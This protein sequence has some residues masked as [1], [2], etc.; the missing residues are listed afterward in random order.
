VVQYELQPGNEGSLR[1]PPAD[2]AASLNTHDMPPFRAFWEGD[3]VGDLEGRGLFDAGEAA[4]ERERR[5]VLRRGMAALLPRAPDP[6]DPEA[7]G[8]AEAVLADRLE[9]LAAG[10]ARLVLVNLEDLWG[11][12]APQNVP[13]TQA[14]R[15]NWRRKA[16]LSFEELSARPE[17]VE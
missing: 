12:T 3:D 11:E 15:P 6:P 7:Q 13:G 1:P 9:W 10:P 16:R 4:A 5:R 17:V 2:S 8:T 14:E